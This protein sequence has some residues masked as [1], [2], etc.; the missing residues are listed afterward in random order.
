MT[1]QDIINKY[2]AENISIDKQ[3]ITLDEVGTALQSNINQ[4][5]SPIAQLDQQIAQYTVSINRKIEQ[6]SGISSSAVIC[7]CGTYLSI[8][9]EDGPPSLVSIGTTYYYEQAKAHRMNIEDTTYTD[10]N[11]FGKLNGTDGSVAF[12]SGIGSTTVVVGADKNSILD[13]VVTN[14]GSG[15]ISSTYYG[16]VLVGGAGTGAKADVVVGASGTVSSVIVNN[17]GYGYAIGNILTISSLSGATFTVSSVGSPILGIGVDTYIVAS[18]G[19]GSVV[20]PDIDITATSICPTTC[21]AYGASI[22][23]I[24]NEIITLRAQRGALFDGVNTLKA[25]NKKKYTQRYGYIFAEANLNS[26]KGIVNN[27]INT[28]NNSTYNQYFS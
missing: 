22:A 24:Q 23:A 19:I 1:K 13:L 4:F 9:S 16:K 26:R 10:T 8:D 3:I 2:Q 15:F 27:I 12:N 17:G 28:L 5:I 7:G 6:L 25:E 21:V 18:S 20:I 11:P 14:P